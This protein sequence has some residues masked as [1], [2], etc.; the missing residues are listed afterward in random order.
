MVGFHNVWHTIYMDGNS[1]EVVTKVVSHKKRAITR[2]FSIVKALHPVRKWS[3]TV[4]KVHAGL[5]TLAKLVIAQ[6]SLRFI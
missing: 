4:H 6:H 1:K 5:E 2:T 3:L